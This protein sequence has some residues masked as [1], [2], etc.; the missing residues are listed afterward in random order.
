MPKSEV[1]V[2]HELE[3]KAGVFVSVVTPRTIGILLSLAATVDILVVLLGGTTTA[4]ISFATVQMGIGCVAVWGFCFTSEVAARL[5]ID[6]SPSG[7]IS[8][9]DAGGD[10]RLLQLSQ[11]P[12]VEDRIS[13]HPPSTYLLAISVPMHLV[14]AFLFWRDHVLMMRALQAVE[15]EEGRSV[16]ASIVTQRERRRRTNSCGNEGDEESECTLVA[17][18]P[19]PAIPVRAINTPTPRGLGVR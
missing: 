19:Y 5:D 8:I 15:D 3:E 10:G 16:M 18:E 14:V 2:D 1:P 12:R 6:V 11:S 13:P 9:F 4:L 17:E 7:C